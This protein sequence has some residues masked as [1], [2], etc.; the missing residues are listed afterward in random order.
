MIVPQSLPSRVAGEAG[1]VPVVESVLS[2]GGVLWASGSVL[3]A[4]AVLWAGDGVWR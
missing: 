2:A 4:G 1:R 3:S